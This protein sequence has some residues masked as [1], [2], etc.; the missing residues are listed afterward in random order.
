M[1]NCDPTVLLE[2]ARCIEACLPPG[3]YSAVEVYLWC[4]TAAMANCDPQVL[5]E[6]AKCIEGC[7]LEGQ[8]QAIIVYLLAKIAGEA[9]SSGE[10]AAAL[11]EKAKCIM[12]L[13]RGQMEAIQVWLTCQIAP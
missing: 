7:T 12:C 2:A 3:N 9:A 6:A 13:T 4:Q 10:D 1:A 8:R 11:L 5:L